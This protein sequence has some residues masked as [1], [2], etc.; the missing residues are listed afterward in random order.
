MDTEQHISCRKPSHLYKQA[1]LATQL[2]K[3]LVQIIFQLLNAICEEFKHKLHALCGYDIYTAE[4]L[5]NEH[6]GDR[7]KWLL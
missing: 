3:H 2:H 7:E 6:L 1:A 5:D 4:P